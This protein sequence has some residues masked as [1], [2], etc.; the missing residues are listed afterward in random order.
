[1]MLINYSFAV[2]SLTSPSK[3]IEMVWNRKYRKRQRDRQTTTIF[4]MA[5]EQKVKKKF[6]Y[7]NKY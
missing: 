7:P 6:K 4:D 3:N 1:M 5:T 2:R